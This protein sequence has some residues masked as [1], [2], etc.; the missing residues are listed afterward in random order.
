MSRDTLLVFFSLLFI[1]MPVFNIGCCS[2]GNCATT[3]KKASGEEI[4]FEE[5]K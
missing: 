4:D 3:A 1:A 2:T 5:I